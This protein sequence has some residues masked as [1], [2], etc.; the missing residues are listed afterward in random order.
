[1]N[2]IAQIPYPDNC[3]FSENNWR[4]LASCWHPVAFSEEVGAKPFGVTLLD[5]PLVAFR[6]RQGVTVAYKYCPHRGADLSLG[7]VDNDRLVCRY[8]G[9]H[10]DASGQCTLVPAEGSEAKVATRLCLTTF[11]TVERYGLIWVCLQPD[12]RIPLPDWGA[13]EEPAN[14]IVT[15]STRWQASAARHTENFLDI[16]HAAWI[17]A[18]TFAPREYPEIGDYSVERQTNALYYKIKTM[19][20]AAN[21]FEAKGT[22]EESLSEYWLHLPFAID[23]KITYGRG[24]E[25]IFDI[26][27][28]ISKNQIRIFMLK[29]RDF[30]L[31]KPVDEW[32]KFQ[33]VV[34][35][36]DRLIVENQWPQHL[37]LDL[38]QEFHIR[39]D[40]ISIAYRR[41][42][43]E[44]GIESGGGY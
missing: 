38:S 31:D 27:S 28:P 43:V 3:S 2:N 10:Y 34:N 9:L 41:S 16:A 6:T 44:L 18:E 17:H 39:A 40:A 42:L 22:V 20:L 7:T 32:L 1:M 36:E 14:Q 12:A 19:F 24:A 8:H 35:E 37:P 15:L 4:I 23:L 5:V 26:A 33:E 29:T 25:H 11:P 30:D 13:L 21:T